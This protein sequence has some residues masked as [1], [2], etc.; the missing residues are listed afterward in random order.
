MKKVQI[1][2]FSQR[3]KCLR[4]RSGLT[5]RELA[6]KLCLAH[7]TISQYEAGVNQ[8]N[9][10]ILVRIA[11]AFGVTTDYLLGVTEEKN[12]NQEAK[13]CLK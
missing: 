7:N 12:N 5:Q 3:V 6:D 11:E 2:G 1:Q 9:M 13:T 10:G 8:P 4:K